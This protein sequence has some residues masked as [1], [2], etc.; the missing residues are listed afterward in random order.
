MLAAVVVIAAV[1]LRQV[2]VKSY[3][4][5]VGRVVRAGS[6]LGVLMETRDPYLPS[7]KGTNERD[8]R[9]SYALWLIPETGDGNVRTIHLSRGVQS[10]SR[11]HTIGVHHVDSGI[12]WLA[13]ENLQGIDIASGQLVTQP[14]SA[15]IANTPISQLMGS[16]EHPLEQYR[17][18]NVTLPSGEW[19]FF[20][21]DDEANA[22]LTPGTRLYDNSTAKGTYKPR[23]LRRISV[24]PGPI[25][26]IDAAALVSAQAF[27]NGAFM[28][29]TKGGPVV[30]FTNPDGFLVVH[31]AGDPVHP[32]VHLS[33]VNT[34]GTI[35]WTADTGIGHLKQVLPHDAL[36]VF[37]GELPNQLTEPALSVVRLQDG[38]VKSVSLK[39]P[40]NSRP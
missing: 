9:Y 31:D 1:L 34:D 23:T 12:I 20:A 11:S 19:L 7:L 22:D 39:G 18:Q 25:P 5:P 38:T 37:V 33:R 2:G 32:G 40:L 21:T 4:H 17:A 16:N 30:R 26:R 24:Q 28:R 13:I 3:G 10:G 36:P 29:E 35:A 27:R 6:H 8:A 15:S 14:A